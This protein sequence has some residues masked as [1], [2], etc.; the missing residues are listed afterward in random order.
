MGNY[1]LRPEFFGGLLI[2]RETFEKWELDIPNMLFL[3]CYAHLND[4]EK[5]K[6]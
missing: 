3:W 6:I 4:I 5:V 1:I 2:C